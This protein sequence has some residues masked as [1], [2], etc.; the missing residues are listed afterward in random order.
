MLRRVALWN[1]LTADFVLQA[2]LGVLPGA[3]LA[4]GHRGRR[5]GG[6]DGR[7]A[8]EDELVHVEVTAGETGLAVGEVELPHPGE[9]LI[10]PERLNCGG[11][12]VETLEPRM[13]RACVVV[14]VCGC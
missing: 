10:E 1:D 12:S 4:A 14:A 7:S 11:I 13:Q 2:G 3:R 9:S 8:F 5:L 6:L